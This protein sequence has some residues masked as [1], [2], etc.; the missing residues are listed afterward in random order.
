MIDFH[1]RHPFAIVQTESGRKVLKKPEN[2]LR[3]FIY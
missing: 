3:A 2:L 1:S